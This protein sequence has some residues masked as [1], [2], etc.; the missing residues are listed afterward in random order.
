M[1]VSMAEF[2]LMEMTSVRDTNHVPGKV[3]GHEF[4]IL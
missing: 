1:S 2:F 3:S 4:E